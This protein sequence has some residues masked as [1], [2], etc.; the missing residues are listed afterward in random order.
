MISKPKTGK[1]V[2]KSGNNAQCIAQAK[3][4]DIPNASK[5]ILFFTIIEEQM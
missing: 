5:L 3:D 4:A 1:L 2:K